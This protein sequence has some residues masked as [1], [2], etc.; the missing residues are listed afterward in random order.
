MSTPQCIVLNKSEAVVQ[1][2]FQAVPK[3]SLHLS[4]EQFDELCERYGDCYGLDW[5]FITPQKIKY[6]DF[7]DGEWKTSTV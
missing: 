1:V 6:Y 4:R 2:T 5:Y 3:A 7:W